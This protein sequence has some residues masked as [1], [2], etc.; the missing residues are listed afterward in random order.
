MIVVATGDSDQSANDDC[1]RFQAQQN[2]RETTKIQITFAVFD[3]QVEM[4]DRPCMVDDSRK[5]LSPS[6]CEQVMQFGTQL[7]PA[8]GTRNVGRQPKKL[9]TNDQ[10]SRCEFEH[11]KRKLQITKGIWRLLLALEYS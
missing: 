8:V 11:C 10:F 2:P 7:A 1:M 6:I 4:Y 3:L 9:S 5:S